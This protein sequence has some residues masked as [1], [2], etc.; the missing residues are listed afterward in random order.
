MPSET[1]KM[2]MEKMK[3]LWKKQDLKI[4]DVIETQKKT[5]TMV[6][7][8]Y[9]V[10]IADLEY[11]EK[12]QNVRIAELENA[13][14]AQKPLQTAGCFWK[15]SA[16]SAMKAGEGPTLGSPLPVSEG[17]GPAPAAKT[18]KA[19]N[20]KKA[21]KSVKAMKTKTA[22]KTMKAMNTKKAKKS[23]KAMK[24]TKT[25]VKPMKAMNTKKAEKAMKAMKTMKVK[26]MKT[27][28]AMKVDSKAK[29]AHDL[30]CAKDSSKNVK[31]MG[32]TIKAINTKKA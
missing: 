2:Q 23:V 15:A 31:T 29:K 27:K 3:K 28:K 13:L 7:Q 9:E 32:W 4:A 16:L 17:E 8:I 5:Q 10:N 30:L 11:N 19:M 21:E 20:T 6:K 1:Q 14:S 25:A 24:K 22:V 12:K 18:M 26:A